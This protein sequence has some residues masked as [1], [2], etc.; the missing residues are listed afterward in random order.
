MDEALLE[1]AM[2]MATRLSLPIPGES[3]EYAPARQALA[4]EIELRRQH[5]R[6]GW[7]DLAPLWM[8][9]DFTPEGRPLNWP[10]KLS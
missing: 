7:T 8:M 2:Q 3:Q 6:L 1:P 10:A 5:E 4:G 9:L